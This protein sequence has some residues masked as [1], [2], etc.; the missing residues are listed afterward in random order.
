MGVFVKEVYQEAYR[1]LPVYW[2]SSTQGSIK[3]EA[4]SDLQFKEDPCKAK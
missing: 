1:A 2:E 4:W 3:E